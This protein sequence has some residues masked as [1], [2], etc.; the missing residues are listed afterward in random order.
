[1]QQASAP[2]NTAKRFTSLSPVMAD[3]SEEFD[4]GN[5]PFLKTTTKNHNQ[6]FFLCSLCFRVCWGQMFLRLYCVVERED[7]L[8]VHSFRL[9]LEFFV[10]L[11]T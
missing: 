4:S 11:L 1:M 2:T 9:G 6:S 7:L 10:S 8:S 3:V 5:Y